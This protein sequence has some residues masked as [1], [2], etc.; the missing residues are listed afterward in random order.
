MTVG[1]AGGKEE[2]PDYK[3]I[4]DHTEAVR[5]VF[6]PSVLS[7]ADIL[8]HFFQEH[9]P[10]MPSFSRQYRSAILV[11]SAEQRKVAEETI[12]SLYSGKK[13]YTRVE[14][15]TTFYQAEDY[16]LKFIEKQN[17]GRRY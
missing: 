3:N 11:N 4:K 2:W 9:S 1:Y 10:M 17:G 12:S 14:D 8:Q 6:D 5:V 16:H 15:F 7:Y 13:I